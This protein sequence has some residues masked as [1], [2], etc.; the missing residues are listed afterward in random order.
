MRNFRAIAMPLLLLAAITAL[1]YAN[2]SVD[3]IAQFGFI[4]DVLLGAALGAGLALLPPAAGFPGKRNA[5]T[6]M[7]WVCGFATLLIIF[8]QYMTLMTGMNIETIA[9]LGNP[10]G[11]M[12]VVEGAMLGYCS[13]FAGRGKA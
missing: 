9:F 6:A 2:V 1:A 10:N 3:R 8:Y 11:R 7:F 5:L 12:R 13:I 4:W